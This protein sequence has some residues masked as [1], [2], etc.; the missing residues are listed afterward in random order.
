LSQYLA[1]RAQQ[2]ENKKKMEMQGIKEHTEGQA[3]AMN[4]LMGA[5]RAALL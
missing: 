3:Q 5:Y 2:E 4:N 1:Q